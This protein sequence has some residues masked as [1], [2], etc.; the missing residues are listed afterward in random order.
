[1]TS[2]SAGIGNHRITFQQLKT[3]AANPTAVPGDMVAMYLPPDALKTSYTQAYGDV[4]VG[5]VMAQSI[6][7]SNAS[8][9]NLGSALEA[10]LAG[11]VGSAV[12]QLANVGISAPIADAFMTAGA[13][14]FI[15]KAGQTFGT[16]VQA[17]ERKVGKI[18]NHHKAIIY[19][20]PGGFR[21]FS[22]SFVMMP[23]SKD[24]AEV[25]NKIV[26][27]FKYYMHPEV[28][29]QNNS[30]RGTNNT[31]SSAGP[32]G[33]TSTSLTLSYPDEFKIRISPR[34][35]DGDAEVGTNSSDGRASQV[36]PL[37]RID[38]CF[39]ESL[40]VDYSTSGQ[41]VFFDDGSEP[42]TTTLQLSFKE[43]V[44]MT[45]EAIRQGF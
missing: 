35:K 30:S 33:E 2:T 5:G 1:M 31:T 17:L 10:G 23:R 41:A 12:S 24:E 38:R 8:S 20:G 19:Q 21:S 37:F 26:H 27:F 45:R 6:M 34:G 32:Q 29:G 18:K 39:L 25:V 44:L 40:N 36:K 9:E 22:Y 28:T 15:E 43:T 7:G 16:A 11:N 14:E 3:T 42:V 13:K 4:D